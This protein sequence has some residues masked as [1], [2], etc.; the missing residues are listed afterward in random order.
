MFLIWL[1][2]PWPNKQISN[3]K[4]IKNVAFGFNYNKWLSGP[5]LKAF[6][7]WRKIKPVT[8]PFSW[9]NIAHFLP[10]TQEGL[11]L[12]VPATWPG[13]QEHLTVCDRSSIL[14]LL[15]QRWM[16][17]TSQVPCF[18]WYDTADDRYEEETQINQLSEARWWTAAA[19][20]QVQIRIVRCWA[21]LLRMK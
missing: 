7:S 18:T 12:V 6:G 1:H 10:S 11:A 2:S 3:R 8:E 16:A 4:A 15:Q 21:V 5:K 20:C 9:A 17:T 14:F 13:K 19:N